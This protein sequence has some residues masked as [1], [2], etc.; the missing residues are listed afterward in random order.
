MVS[1][2]DTAR[3]TGLGVAV[4]GASIADLSSRAVVDMIVEVAL[5]VTSS[6]LVGVMKSS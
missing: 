2:R 3:W 4:E 1:L 5:V 6:H